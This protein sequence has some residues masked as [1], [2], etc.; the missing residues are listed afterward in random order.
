MGRQGLVSPGRT[1]DTSR[2]GSRLI[3][4]R[5]PHSLSLDNPHHPTSLGLRTP[6][7]P[8]PVSVRPCETVSLTEPQ[9][10]WHPRSQTE[11]SIHIVRVHCPRTMATAAHIETG[12]ESGLSFRTLSGCSR[13]PF[14]SAMIPPVLAFVSSCPFRPSS[15]VC[16]FSLRELFF[17]LAGRLRYPKLHSLASG[18]IASRRFH[19]C[20]SLLPVLSSLS[21]SLSIRTSPIF[22]DDY[23]SGYFYST[24]LKTFRVDP[25]YER[26]FDGW[27]VVPLSF[28]FDE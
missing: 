17:L 20:P 24:I 12:F 26:S 19:F 23:R 15:Q 4:P 1:S 16:P 22:Q 11:P 10:L 28:D 3:T 21:V 8:R 6:P 27:T 14:S 13:P 9:G 25:T 5:G 7:W 18:I 2:Q